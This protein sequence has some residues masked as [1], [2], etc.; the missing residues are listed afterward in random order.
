MTQFGK[1]N[2]IWWQKRRKFEILAQGNGLFDAECNFSRSVSS[3]ARI[4]Q[5]EET[6]KML[7]GKVVVELSQ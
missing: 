3:S 4:V 5:M 6:T 7:N 1:K 2:Q